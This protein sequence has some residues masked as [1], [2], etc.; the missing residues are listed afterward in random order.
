QRASPLPTKVVIMQL[1]SRANESSQGARWHLI[2]EAGFLA[3]AARQ[4]QRRGTS[5]QVALV[6]SGEALEPTAAQQR[7]LTLGRFESRCKRVLLTA[8]GFTAGVH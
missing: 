8:D 4:Q 7:S 1:V 3:Q 2:D 5:K 6:A